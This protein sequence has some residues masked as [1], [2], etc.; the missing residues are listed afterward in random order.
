MNLELMD[1]DRKLLN[2]AGHMLSPE[3][4]LSV[5]LNGLMVWSAAQGKG[6]NKP[7]DPSQRPSKLLNKGDMINSVSTSSSIRD[8]LKEP[9]T[10]TIVISR[11]PQG[12]FVQSTSLDALYYAGSITNV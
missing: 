1:G 4:V 7:W 2:D 11:E 6:L 3:H 5:W 10:K 8:A 12:P 9:G